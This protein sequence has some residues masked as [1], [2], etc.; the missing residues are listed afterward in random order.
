MQQGQAI[1]LNDTRNN[2]KYRVKKM[3]DGNVWMIDNLKLGST[4]STT[5]LTPTDTNIASNYTLPQISNSTANSDPGETTYCSSS[6]LVHTHNPGN[7]TGCGYLYTWK[8]AMAETSSNSGYSISPKG[9]GLHP[10]SGTKSANE[11]SDK[12]LAVA[13]NSN[14]NRNPVYSTT[15][16]KNFGEG[17]T[18]YPAPWLGV[19]SGYYRNNFANQGSHGYYCSSTELVK[20][21]A[22][23]LYFYSNDLNT[24]NYFGKSD[25]HAVRS[26]L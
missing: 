1:V 7:T 9:W 13:A 18:N 19:Y 22:Y 12:M 17:D 21:D 14:S 4:T 8:I 6:G 11:L 16:Y 15:G 10:N 5:T 20:S 3:P 25:G 23:S 2:Q 26:V 24:K